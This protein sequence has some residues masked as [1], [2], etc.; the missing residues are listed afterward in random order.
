M[1]FL[2]RFGRNG[3]SSWT[4]IQA[5]S[6]TLRFVRGDMEAPRKPRLLDFGEALAGSDKAD[7][8]RAAK[9]LR[10][11]TGGRYALL[12]REPDYRIH[13]M[14]APNVPPAELKSAM[15]WHLKEIID[16]PVEEASYDILDLPADRRGADQPR[17]VYAVAA[18]QTVLKSY[19]DQ[20]DKARLPVTVIDVPEMAQ[21]NIAALY[22][23]ENRAVALLHLGEEDGLLTVSAG[24]E[25]YL[26]RRLDISLTQI[27]STE[28]DARNDLFSRIL[29]QLQRTLDNFERQFSFVG[30]SKLLLGPQPEDTG[31]FDYLSGNIGIRVE[32]VDLQ[33]VIDIPKERDFDQ[34]AQWRYL[35]LIGCSLRTEAQI[36]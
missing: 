15:K 36:A 30:I 4:V 26:A 25:L 23:E 35:H 14:D 19:V 8:S 3:Q 10:I 16:F 27:R 22:E 9:T 11:P 1:T 6:S 5:G 7:L 32:M 13:L 18:R 21:R 12:L 17:S 24:G 31:L 2:P 28:G 33:A 29:L 20:L 34:Q